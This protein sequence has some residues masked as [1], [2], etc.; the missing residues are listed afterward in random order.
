[1]DQQEPDPNGQQDLM[2]RVVQEAAAESRHDAEVQA[3]ATS[4]MLARGVLQVADSPAASSAPARAPRSQSSTSTST[5]TSTKSR[6]SASRPRTR[7]VSKEVGCQRGRSCAPRPVGCE[8]AHAEL[9]TPVAEAEVVARMAGAMHRTFRVHYNGRGAFSVR[10]PRRA[11]RAC[12]S[13]EV[14]TRNA[15]E[16]PPLRLGPA[17]SARSSCSPALRAWLQPAKSKRQYWSGAL[18]AEGPK[19]PPF[20]LWRAQPDASENS[21]EA[22]EQRPRRRSWPAV[23]RPRDVSDLLRAK[24]KTKAHRVMLRE[25]VAA[26]PCSAPMGLWARCIAPSLRSQIDITRILPQHPP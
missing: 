24:P 4:E 5:S 7:S 2:T 22:R 19:P 1:M 25:L 8:V 9:T 15:E 10:V 11:R 6:R 14:V 21:S 13:T 16:P 23:A 18:A 20:T 17:A 12:A 3:A 26:A